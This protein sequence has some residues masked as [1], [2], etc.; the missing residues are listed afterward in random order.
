M[1]KLLAIANTV[2]LEGIRRRELYAVIVLCC[3]L[4]AAVMSLDFF[5]LGG[6]DKFYREI[7][8][9]IMSAGTGIAVLVLSTRQ[10]PREFEFRTIY[11]LL[12]RPISRW[13][14]ITGK[15]IGVFGAACFCFGLFMMIYLFGLFHIGA[16]IDWIFFVQYI[17][18]QLIL[19]LLLAAL[20]SALSLCMNFDAA[21]TMGLLFFLGTNLFSSTVV[22]LYEYAGAGGR[23]LLVFLNY[24]LPQL[25][26]FDLSE[27]LVHAE[28]WSPLSA[29]LLFS[30]TLYGAVYILL[31]GGLAYL[32]F[33]RRSL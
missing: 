19:M 22:A 13:T 6:L 33:R 15:L 31:Y 8:L 23:I 5:G 18:L 10:L 24:L 12:A 32:L 21:L 7:A 11:T 3:G 26:L 27:K 4:I 16:E 17:Y 1:R 25:V 2:L 28:M 20:G 30:L 9:K 14:F 29:G